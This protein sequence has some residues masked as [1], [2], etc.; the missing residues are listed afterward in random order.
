MRPVL[1][2][3]LGASIV[4]ASAPAPA[5]A[6]AGPAPSSK[7]DEAAAKKLYTSRKYPEAAAAFEQLYAATGAP[8]HL[9]NAAMA[10]ELAG[11]EGHA[12]LL[13]R[14]Y[15]TLGA[16]SFTELDRANDRLAALERRTAP[17][18]LVVVP[19]ALVTQNLRITLE[20]APTG[21]EGDR[22]R[23]PLVL[24]GDTLPLIA[25][26]DA[27]GAFDLSLEQGTWIVTATADGRLPLREELVVDTSAA[28]LNLEPAKIPPPAV[29]VTATIGPP[30]L[31]EQHPDGIEVT[32]A[33]EGEIAR[34][35]R[36]HHSPVTWELTPGTYRFTVRAPGYRPQE[37]TVTVEA[38]PVAV[39]EIALEPEPAQ[40]PDPPPPK[41]GPDRWAVGLGAAAGGS[42]LVGLVVLGI[43]A[44]HWSRTIDRYS[45]FAALEDAANWNVASHNLFRSWK[46]HG[47][48]AGL[49]GAGLGL[50]L[51]ALGMQ[52]LPRDTSAPKFWAAGTAVGGA[53]AITGALLVGRAG[54][55]LQN[56][57]WAHADDF[58]RLDASVATDM[59]GKNH[60]VGAAATL[61]GFGAGLALSS[62]LG[63]VRRPTPQ[64]AALVP[65]ASGLLLSGRF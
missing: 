35:E 52:Y 45:Q 43:G 7:D 38:D 57:Q 62:V 65:T 18:R 14:R 29:P 1:C 44:S 50:G 21:G 26:T 8:K 2:A 28:Q 60:H 30:A 53:L 55:G 4:L 34:T 19:D 36:V 49:L 33:Q 25:A 22:G 20:R 13:L 23:V 42:A 15:V 39:R 40:R 17:I 6:F 5:R 32:I 59:H 3:I 31:F 64:R 54:L 46:T 51:G 48:G 58:T 47:A 56:T 16:L 9:F 27:P 24:A 63:L 61:L 11:H 10:R 41:P 12:F 37:V